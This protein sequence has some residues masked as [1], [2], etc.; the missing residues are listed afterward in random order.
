MYLRR[1]TRQ[2]CWALLVVGTLLTA[3]AAAT[4]FSTPVHRRAEALAG[5]A[6]FATLVLLPSGIPLLLHYRSGVQTGGHR[7][8]ILKE[9]LRLSCIVETDGV[10]LVVLPFP[11]EIRPP[12]HCGLAAFLQNCHDTP[13]DVEI[14][15]SETPFRLVGRQAPYR[16]RLAGGET[17]V[18]FIPGFAGPETQP[19][20][21]AV[22]YR[23]AVRR[24]GRVGKRVIRS[25]AARSGVGG[26]RRVMLV[27]RDVRP[28]GDAVGYPGLA[29]RT[30]YQPIVRGGEETF[31]DES[32]AFLNLEG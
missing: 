23:V 1:G 22:G 15:V 17:G 5:T 2:A 11:D 25:E 4:A 8:D 9:D 28:L 12:S 19:G 18:L 26:G 3:A 20:E 6:V 7:R 10:Q 24:P 14:H 29:G 16:A 13:R 21:Y 30:G 31:L 27:V 32:L